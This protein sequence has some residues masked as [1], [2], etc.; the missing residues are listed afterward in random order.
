[1]DAQ[2]S[3]FYPLINGHAETTL[4]VGPTIIYQG[5][6]NSIPDRFDGMTVDDFRITDTGFIFYLN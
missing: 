6:L 2:L 3:Q 4:Q 5:P 1:M